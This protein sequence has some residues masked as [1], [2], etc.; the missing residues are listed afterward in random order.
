MEN[1]DPNLQTNAPLSSTPLVDDVDDDGLVEIVLGGA[2]DS[3]GA[4]GAIYIWN[5]GGDVDGALPWPM[6]RHDVFHTGLY[7]SGPR[8]PR[9]AFPDQITVFHEGD[10]G[11]PVVRDVLV[12][13]EGGS[14]IDWQIEEAIDRLSVNPT[15]GTVIDT[16]P[17]QIQ[18]DTQRL[19]PGWHTLGEVT[20]TGQ[21]EGVAVEGNPAVATIRV[22]VGD[23]YRFYLPLAL[24]NQ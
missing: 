21:F 5:V 8:A 2:A 13:N 18:I 11:E 15:S 16:M 3:D 9:L 12:R 4:T 19:A 10:S 14:Y 20:V 24:R 22:Y 23:V 17:V 6:F 1:N 7:G